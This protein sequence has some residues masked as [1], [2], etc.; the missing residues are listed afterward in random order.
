[1]TP[2][3]EDTRVQVACDAEVEL[4]ARTVGMGFF[5]SGELTEEEMEIGRAVFQTGFAQ[6]YLGRTESGEAAAGAALSVREG[7]ALLFAD[8]AVAEYRRTG[9]HASLIRARLN[10]AIACGC[11]LAS[12][13]TAP[14]GASQRNYERLGFQVAYTKVLLAEV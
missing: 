3:P 9:W 6:C 8:S 13:S 12:A 14:G 1:M 5:E 10:A 4:W 7:L 11:D 2:Y